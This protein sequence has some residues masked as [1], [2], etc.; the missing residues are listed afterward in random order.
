MKLQ[1]M[2]HPSFCGGL[3]ESGSRGARMPNHAM[4][5]HEWGTHFSAWV[6][7]EG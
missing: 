2:G 5:L 3:E 4:K 6:T 7:T 1:R